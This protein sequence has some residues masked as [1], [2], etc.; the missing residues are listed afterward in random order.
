MK[1]K[2]MNNKKLK[3]LLGPTSF[4]E[5][6]P[7]PIK[8]MEQNGL[9]I[10]KNPQGR[11]L[12]REDLIELLPGVDGLVAG[13]EPLSRDILKKSDLRV[14]SRCGSGISNVDVDACQ[15][16][17]IVFKFTPY[18]PTQAVAELTVSMIISL[19]RDTWFM[20]RNL[21]KG[22]WTKSV[23]YQLKGK[24]V[25]IIGFGRIGRRTAHLL[26]PFDVNLIVVDPWITSEEET[27][28]RLP[29][30]DAL[31]V[32][33]ILIIH[34]S[35]DGQIIGKEELK[36][37]KQGAIICNAARGENVDEDALL[38]A[39]DSGHVGGLWMDT[40]SVEPYNGPLCDHSKVITTPHVGSYT[41]EGRFEMEMEA[42]QNII[43]GLSEYKIQATG[44][45]K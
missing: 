14:V 13:L 40:F 17:G 35:G 25:T 6:D 39:L 23:G 29:L 37:M 41:A 31:P 2:T 7:S 1:A 27:F 30:I 28:Q 32:S 36:M 26:A 10:I 20:H 3:I 12:T 8:L 44:D 22:K 42:A 38:E 43:D 9:E 15:E 16:L 18:G 24:T 19:L 33:D 45:V 5:N 11:K 21:S 34:A 4:G